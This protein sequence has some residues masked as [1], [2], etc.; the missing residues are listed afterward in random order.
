MAARLAMTGIDMLPYL[1][2]SH[3]DAPFPGGISLSGQ[4]GKFTPDGKAQIWPGN[5]FVC[6]VERPGAGFDA[7]RAL[8][9]EVKMSR[10]ARFYNFLPPSS[11]HMTVFQGVS[12]GER[13]GAFLPDG[14]K[15]E[16]SLDEINTAVREATRDLAF[17]PTRE[18]QAV[19]FFCAQG[20]I[21][22]GV[23][24]EGEAP[25][26]EIRNT[27]RAATGIN[28]P[29]FGDYVFHITLAYLAEW[30]TEPTGRAIIDFA[31]EL[32]ERYGPTLGS[33]PLGPV[34][35]CAFETMHHFE[36]LQTLA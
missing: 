27:L 30:V 3:T 36:P 12:P 14:V 21:V 23:G 1:T 15:D 13:Q 34:E 18:V 19:N 24:P 9:E 22:T 6:H 33:I 16:A 28:P 25:L 2:G 29:G 10:F 4:G 7:L 17:A 8:Q 35:F 11:F 5:T 20:L 31:E 26:R 32:M